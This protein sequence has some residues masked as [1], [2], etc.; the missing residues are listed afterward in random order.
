[1]KSEIGSD[2]QNGEILWKEA[3]GWLGL[4]QV[5]AINGN[6]IFVYSIHSANKPEITK[7]QAVCKVLSIHYRVKHSNRGE[8]MKER[9]KI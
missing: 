3:K 7:C 8:T 4:D 9:R 2:L 5:R 1:M 6:P